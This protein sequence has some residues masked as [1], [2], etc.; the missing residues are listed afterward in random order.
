MRPFWLDLEPWQLGLGLTFWTLVL[1]GLVWLVLSR[2]RASDER[3]RWLVLGR[4]Q[5]AVERGLP[6][7]AT[8]RALG[9][10][11]ARRAERAPPSWWWL[12]LLI[13]PGGLLLLLALLLLGWLSRR[14]LRRESE[15]AQDVAARLQE[16]GLEAG[17]VSAPGAFPAP[18]PELLRRA[19][20][21]G[22][23]PAALE[24]LRGLLRQGAGARQRVRAGLLYPGG[25]F[26]VLL[27][28]VSF[29]QLVIRPK[30]E[31]ILAFTS[32]SPPG[33]FLGACLATEQ[34]VLLLVPLLLFALWL[35]AGLATPGARG[36]LAVVAAGLPGARGLQRAAVRACAARLL[37]AALR[38]G[39][40]L[41][42]ALRLLALSPGLDPALARAAAARSEEGA[43]LLQACQAAGLLVGATGLA[44]GP[45]PELA[46]ALADLHQSA[47][48][49]RIEALAALAFPLALLA[50]G[51]L[52]ALEYWIPFAYIE[53]LERSFLW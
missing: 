34:A 8:V 45:G 35:L 5:L 38:A 30:L 51:A 17:L 36:V 2:R 27:L 13:L 53:T 49:A 33:G 20:E 46:E 12:L 24:Q 41:P 29:A 26:L 6:L 44:P 22:T 50:L 11:L 19:G 16:G 37:A 52:V 48:T 9:E 25:V 40:P 10:D 32:P 15:L 31:E 7:P 1:G 23:L 42:E 47:L 43:P 21:L 3:L 18:W 14:R 4:L 39:L 28:P